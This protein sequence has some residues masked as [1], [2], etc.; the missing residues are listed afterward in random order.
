MDEHNEHGTNEVP[1][2]I[3]IPAETNS[4]MVVVTSNSGL[5]TVEGRHTAKPTEKMIL[6]RSM[7]EVCTNFP[8]G[9]LA[10]NF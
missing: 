5:M 8:I 4:P 9:I 1:T 10:R 2:L 3:T 6:R 7:Y